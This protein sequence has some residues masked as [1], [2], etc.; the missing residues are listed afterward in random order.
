MAREPNSE[1]RFD[2]DRK[3]IFEA[4]VLVHLNSAYT[5]ARYLARRSDLADDI[6]QEA[7]L[8]AYRSFDSE[9]C[10]N[11]RAWLLAIVRN[12][13]LTWK[14]LHREE[15]AHFDI[16]ASSPGF[17]GIE[18]QEQETPETIL[19]QHEEE[20]NMRSLIEGIPHPFREVLVLRDIEDMSYRDIAE[21]TG[22]PIG[23]VMSRLAR[24]R[25]MFAEAWKS[26]QIKSP[27]EM[28]S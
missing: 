22:I 3:A 10:S 19:M 20:S 11:P 26:S 12:C 23:T 24:S 1:R 7:L 25:K 18:T 28:Q 5:M 16:E 15:P 21:I 2:A 13:Y 9:R 8:R 17:A 4:T 6:V 27:K 14:S